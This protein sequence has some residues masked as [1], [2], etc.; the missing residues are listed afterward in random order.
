MK[1]KKYLKLTFTELEFLLILMF[2]PVFGGTNG[3]AGINV[4]L[5]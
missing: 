1:N 5:K 2:L 4:G 3:N